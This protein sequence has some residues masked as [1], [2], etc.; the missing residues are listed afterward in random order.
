MNKLK[1][2]LVDSYAGAFLVA[3]L[4]STGI[5]QF[6]AALSTYFSMRLQ[7]PD[8]RSALGAPGAMLFRLIHPIVMLFIAFLILRWLFFPLSKPVDIEDEPEPAE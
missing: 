5:S 4:T 2:A 3:L 6:V 7:G 1:T 8:V